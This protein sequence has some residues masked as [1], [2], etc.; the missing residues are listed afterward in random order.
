MRGKRRNGDSDIGERE[1][2]KR[3]WKIKISLEIKRSQ[4]CIE[5]DFT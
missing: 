3:Y 1:V 4:V 2:K 5:N